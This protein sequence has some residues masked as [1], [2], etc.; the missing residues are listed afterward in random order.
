MVFL[1]SAEEVLPINHRRA[2]CG[3]GTIIEA[4]DKFRRLHSF[5]LRRKV[6]I[7]ENVGRHPGDRGMRARILEADPLRDGEPRKALAIERRAQ[8]KRGELPVEFGVKDPA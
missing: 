3:P 8:S 1:L 2:L 4:I 6:A 5:P 7:A